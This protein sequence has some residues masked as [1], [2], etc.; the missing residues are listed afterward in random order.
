MSSL[1]KQYLEE[2]TLKKVYEE[3]DY[4]LTYTAI[5]TYLMVFD[6]F[7]KKEKRGYKFLTA[8]KKAKEIA[9]LNGCNFLLLQVETGLKGYQ[10]RINLYRKLGFEFFKQKGLKVYMIKEVK[11]A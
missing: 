5:N 8:Y 1:Y 9:A 11:N 2:I 3:K 6:L 10:K 4:F 7:I